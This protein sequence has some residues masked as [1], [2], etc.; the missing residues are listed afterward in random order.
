MGCAA[1]AELANRGADVEL[2]ERGLVG[3]STS[4]SMG[5]SRIFRLSYDE[6]DYIHFAQHALELWSALEA[7]RNTS[8]LVETGGIDIG[9]SGNPSLGRIAGALSSAAVPFEV[10]DHTALRR[11]Y[12][13]LRLAE[14]VRAVF[15]PNTCVLRADRCIRALAAAARDAGS[16]I[17]EKTDVRAV[18]PDG[19]G[20]RIETSA[21]VHNADLALLCA[22]PGICSFLEPLELDVPITI[23]FEQSVYFAAQGDPSFEPGH[24]PVCIGHFDGPRL[25]SIFPA[26]DDLGVKVMIENKKAAIDGRDGGIDP[27]LVA[28]VERRARD[29]MPRLS[30]TITRVDRAPYTLLP[31]GDF[32]IDRHPVFPQII[33]C[34]AC[35]GHGFKF[36]PAIGEMMADLAEG[37]EAHWRFSFRPDRFTAG[38]S[39]A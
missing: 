27:D 4:S 16:R 9:E 37:C 3:A 29:L 32:L 30:T 11:A 7:E 2:F 28:R 26:L 36:A 31:D 6:C 23:S 14:N 33:L 35:S 15:Q 34:S 25:M 22:G 10:W 24:F 1:A 12:P 19:S 21:G 18:V 39:A 5:P 20:V 38:S 13:Q 8:L 17:Y